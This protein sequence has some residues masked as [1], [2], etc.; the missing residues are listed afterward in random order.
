[1]RSKEC[2]SDGYSGLGLWLLT[3]GEG[4]A[5]SFIG[6]WVHARVQTVVLML[7]VVQCGDKVYGR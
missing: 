6:R 5:S 1:M 3:W 2:S 4:R 7:C